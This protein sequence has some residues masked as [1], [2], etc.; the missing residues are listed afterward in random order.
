MDFDSAEKE[1]GRKSKKSKK[2]EKEV[3]QADR[4][5]G[6]VGKRRLEGLRERRISIRAGASRAGRP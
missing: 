3:G 4:I 5:V 2:K 6:L 1:E